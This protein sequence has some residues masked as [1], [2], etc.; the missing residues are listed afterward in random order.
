[1]KPKP[2]I[3]VLFLSKVSLCRYLSACLLC[4]ARR[5]QEIL[6]S[7]ISSCWTVTLHRLNWKIDA[8]AACVCVCVSAG[9]LSVCSYQ[10]GW[11]TKI[12]IDPFEVLFLFHQLSHTHTHTIYSGGIRGQRQAAAPPLLLFPFWKITVHF[13][14]P[15]PNCQHLSYLLS[16]CP[17]LLKSASTL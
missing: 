4:S 16:N 1:M 7:M 14:L 2:E 10:I 8:V 12:M 6:V 11:Q 15:L 3:S 9:W 5:C 13:W 17:E